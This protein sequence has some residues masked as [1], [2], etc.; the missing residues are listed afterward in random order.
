MGV[1]EN[2]NFPEIRNKAVEKNLAERCIKKAV[3]D[4]RENEMGII[5]TG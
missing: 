1:Q 5:V 4:T 2:P 3:Q